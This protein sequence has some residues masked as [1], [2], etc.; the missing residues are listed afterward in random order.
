MI[1]ITPILRISVHTELSIGK[2][3][4][5]AAVTVE[6]E[7][8][9]ITL[10]I[11]ANGIVRTDGNIDIDV[12]TNIVDGKIL[13]TVPFG[14]EYKVTLIPKEDCVINSSVSEYKI[15]GESAGEKTVGASGRSFENIRLSAGKELVYTLSDRGEK[16]IVNTA[17]YDVLYEGPV[18]A[19]DDDKNS[20]S[21][22]ESKNTE[23]TKNNK[24]DS[25]DDSIK[26]SKENSPSAVDTV[27]TGDNSS[28]GVIVFLM[29]ISASF[30]ASFV[31]VSGKNRSG[32]K[33]RS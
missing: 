26:D 22:E 20:N 18:N 7:G 11:T 16:G 5:D 29:M 2:P 6:Y 32:K 25:T 1:P 12:F 3:E 4:C 28:S 9:K 14:K 19:S 30:A 31:L 33:N 8:N 21:D 17:E 13:F 10:E 24:K 15:D 27:N 23:D